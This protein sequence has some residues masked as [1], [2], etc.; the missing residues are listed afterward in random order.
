[1]LLFHQSRRRFGLLDWRLFLSFHKFDFAPAKNFIK[2]KSSSTARP[3]ATGAQSSARRERGGVSSRVPTARTECCALPSA[4]GRHSIAGQ[5][6]SYPAE[7]RLDVV[8]GIHTPLNGF[9]IPSR[10]ILTPLRGI[11]MPSDG[12]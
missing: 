12:N 10:G 1:M 6:L 5:G 3:G 4:A 7:G 2:K 11:Y 9:H 8:F